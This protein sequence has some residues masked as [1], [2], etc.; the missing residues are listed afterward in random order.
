[1][2]LLA[3]SNLYAE[4]NVFT[5]NPDPLTFLFDT[6]SSPKNYHAANTKKEKRW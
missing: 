4:I 3:L 2:I 5:K 1:M 6:I